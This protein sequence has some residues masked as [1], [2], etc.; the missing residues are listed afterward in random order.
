MEMILFIFAHAALPVTSSW[1]LTSTTWYSNVP[2]TPEETLQSLLR[3]GE[4]AVSLLPH[5]FGQSKSQEDE[6]TGG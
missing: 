5:T 6:D 2:R 4:V 3:P 1:P